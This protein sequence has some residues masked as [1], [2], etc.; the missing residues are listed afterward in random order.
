MQCILEKT[1]TKFKRYYPEV[2]VKSDNP[3]YFTIQID[4]D[5]LQDGEYIM[6]LYKDNN[7]EIA[8]ELMRIGNYKI[9]EYKVEKKFTQYVRK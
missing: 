5:G 7:E 6:T 8:K 4:V 2:E 1:S 3:I 9:I